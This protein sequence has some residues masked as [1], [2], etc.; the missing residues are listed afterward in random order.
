MLGVGTAVIEVVLIIIMICAIRSDKFHVYVIAAYSI[1]LVFGV[2]ATIT[3]S[4]T[5]EAAQVSRLVTIDEWEDSDSTI[6]RLVYDRD[7]GVEYYQYGDNEVSMCPRYD[8]DG[9]IVVYNKG[10]NAVE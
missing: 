6:W 5:S 2:Y 10:S 9:N 3:E 1:L 4:S 8:E 7:T